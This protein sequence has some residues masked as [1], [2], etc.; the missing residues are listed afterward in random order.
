M[1][2]K[3]A[4]MFIITAFHL[5][6]FFDY[7][8]G[9]ELPY[10][11]GELLVRF[12]PKSTG[13]QRTTQEK[14]QLLFS[15]NAG[16][17]KHSYK[18]VR[19]LALVKLP[20][21]VKV[22]D[23]LAIL[24]EKSEFIYVRP[25]HKIKQL[26]TIPNDTDFDELWGM[27]NEGQ[28]GGTLDADIDAPEAWDMTTDSHDTIVA[29]IDSGIDYNHPDLAGN[30]WVNEAELNG[31]PDVDDDNNTYVDDIYG[32]DFR[33]NDGDPID[34]SFHGTHCA[35]TI[36]AVGAKDGD[37]AFFDRHVQGEFFEVD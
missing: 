15:L 22:A 35:G 26:S 25:N 7:A 23:A 19:G 2:S 21:N 18:R 32:Y 20:E 14:N 1:F 33:N 8:V 28:T 11:E 27:H 36:G 30:M 17:V 4:H 9:S 13:L 34:D 12:A 5:V 37:G 24:K 29:V 31:V 10:K 16:E 3:T 6:F